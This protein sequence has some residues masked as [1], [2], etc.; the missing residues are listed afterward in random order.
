[1][2]AAVALAVSEGTADASRAR[3]GRVV[4][5]A[6]REVSEYLG[7]TPTVC[8]ASYIDPRVIELY[9]AGK[10]IAAALGDLGED[11]AF[12]RPATHGVVEGAVLALLRAHP[13]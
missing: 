6:V 12:G 7:N 2:V 3:R 8:R 13:G 5:R 10:T 1:M 9:E 11:G 4:A